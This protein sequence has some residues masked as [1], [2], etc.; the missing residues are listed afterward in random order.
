MAQPHEHAR[1]LRD[2]ANRLRIVGPQITGSLS[3]LAEPLA[4]W[5]DDS[6][7]FCDAVVGA[8]GHLTPT[9]KGNVE[10][11]LRAATVVLHGR[12]GKYA[13]G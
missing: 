7:D 9:A 2:A 3:G 12:G 10:V 4:E 5:L 13:A 8:H 6:A 1:T 11:A